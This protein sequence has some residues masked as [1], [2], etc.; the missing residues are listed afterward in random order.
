MVCAKCQKLQKTTRL[1]TPGVKRKNDIYYGSP[2]AAGGASK[3]AGK[4]PSATLGNTGIAKSKLLSKG[5]Q[6]PYAAYASSCRTCKTRTEQGRALCNAC[7]YRA[8]CE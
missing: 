5:A 2:A 4:K 1:A 6:N 7:A 8:N 3:E